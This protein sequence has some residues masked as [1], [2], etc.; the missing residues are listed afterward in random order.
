MAIARRYG[1]N[2]EADERP[3]L[4]GKDKRHL[5]K[6]LKESRKGTSD[7]MKRYLDKDQ[8]KEFKQFQEV[9]VE[10]MRQRAEATGQEQEARQEEETQQED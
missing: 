6:E 1:L 5:S 9:Q 10:N 4:T 7:R 2:L 3:E 8:M